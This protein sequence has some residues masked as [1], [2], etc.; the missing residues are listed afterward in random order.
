MNSRLQQALQEGL[1]DGKLADRLRELG[2]YVIETQADAEAVCEALRSLPPSGGER[3]CGSSPVSSILQLFECLYADDC[4]AARVLYRRGVAELIQMLQRLDVTCDSD[5]WDALLTLKVLAA[6]GT[7]AGAEQVVQ[8]ALRPLDDESFL[9]S[10]VMQQYS[11]SNPQTPYVYQQLAQTLPTG[12]IA[13][14]L[15]DSANAALLAGAPL[16]HPFN[17]RPGRR[18]LHDWLAASNHQASSYALSAAAALPFIDPPDRDSLLALAFEHADAAVQMEAS[19]ASAK[20]GSKAGLK[21][22]A[23]CC[24]D[25]HRALVALRYLEELGRTDLAP[26][27]SLAPDFQA[28]AV[29]CDWLAH[30]NEFGGPPDHIELWDHRRFHWPPSR[31]DRE[32]RL[33]LYRYDDHTGHDP[34]F[35]GVAMSGSI[36]WSFGEQHDSQL[37]PEDYYALHCCWELEIN[38]DPLA[39]ESRS[40]EV[41]H[42]I[43][44][45]FNPTWPGGADNRN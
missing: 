39:P 36:P 29:I 17:T 9:W 26:P 18:R 7:R 2:E 35:I 24:L 40:L 34:P 13:V 5:Q 16:P 45:R 15:L 38:G 21:C 12:F 20:L 42:A 1:A 44:R 22:L 30:P 25:P 33:F 23:R 19:W 10:E 37:S 11:A 8:A 31:K 28:Q 4:P 14:A 27:E 6:Y 41:G 3:S 43:L 32:L